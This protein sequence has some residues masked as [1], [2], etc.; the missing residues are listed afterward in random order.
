MQTFRIAPAC[1]RPRSL[2]DFAPGTV[3]F[4]VD[5]AFAVFRTAALPVDKALRSVDDRANAAGVVQ[6]ALCAGV[7]A[8]PGKRHSVAACKRASAL[9]GVSGA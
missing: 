9:R 3:F 4:L 7:T 2:S 1:E 8:K 6:V 5:L